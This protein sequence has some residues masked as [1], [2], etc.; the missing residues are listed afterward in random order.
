[1]IPHTNDGNDGK[2]QEKEESPYRDVE[3]RAYMQPKKKQEYT[4]V[5]REREK[6]KLPKAVRLCISSSG[7]QQTPRHQ[8]LRESFLACTLKTF[9]EN[10][11]QLLKTTRRH[12]ASGGDSSRE[13][14]NANRSKS[15][16]WYHQRAKK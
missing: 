15:A 4:Y 9:A 13:E 10:S 11:I 2:E 7:H 6:V 16:R 14:K 1:L 8:V 3:L 5:S 12:D